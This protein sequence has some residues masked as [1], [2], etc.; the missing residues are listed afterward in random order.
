MSE[1]INLT[2]QERHILKITRKAAKYLKNGIPSKDAFECSNPRVYEDDAFYLLV[3][4]ANELGI[5]L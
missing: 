3:K 4:I 5:K 2:K 1:A